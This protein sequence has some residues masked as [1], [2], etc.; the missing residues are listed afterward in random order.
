MMSGQVQP[1]SIP[2]PVRVT[3]GAI[4]DQRGSFHACLS[5]GALEQAGA[6]GFAVADVGWSRSVRG[7]LRGLA[8]ATAAAG[9]KMVVCPRG[10]ILDV[11]VDLRAGSPVF[12]AWHLEQLGEDTDAALYIPPGFGHGFLALT[13]GTVVMYLRAG[14]HDQ[15]AERRVNPLDPELGI[16]WP[17]QPPKIL[18]PRDAAAPGLAEALA[19]GIL[20]GYPGLA[21]AAVT[22]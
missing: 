20:P 17:G 22:Q 15:A 14:P 12:G 16:G 19:A 7:A 21:A 18:S 6:A 10:E 3:A 5:P 2:G 4:A 11:V 1:L 8:V 13:A 9:A